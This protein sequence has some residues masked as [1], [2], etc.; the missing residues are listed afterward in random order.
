MRI[1]KKKKKKKNGLQSIHYCTD[2]KYGYNMGLDARNPVVGGLRTSQAQVFSQR[3]PYDTKQSS[4]FRKKY[5]RKKITHPAFLHFADMEEG[6][7]H[8]TQLTHISL[9]S[10]FVG[11]R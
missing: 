3:G 7:F 11:H 10:F 5:P 4:V 6:I 8:T 2:H 1:K 9:T